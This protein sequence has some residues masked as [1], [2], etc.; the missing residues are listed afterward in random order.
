M[1]V[2]VQQ[3]PQLQELGRQ[4]DREFGPSIRALDELRRQVDRKHGPGIRALLQELRR[5]AAPGIRALEELSKQAAPVLKGD[6]RLAE[7]VGRLETR[8]EG[9]L[10]APPEPELKTVE[11]LSADMGTVIEAA[12]A[13]DR[14]K[15]KTWLTWLLAGRRRSRSWRRRRRG[16][17]A[18]RR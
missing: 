6:E 11:A 15:T 7:A 4:L 13:E 5:Q 10:A 18:G 1:E 8:A 9:S 14:E 17:S 3:S 12:P 16:R 2:L